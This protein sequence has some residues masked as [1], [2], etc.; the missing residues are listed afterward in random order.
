MHAK[1]MNHTLRH[2]FF[3]TL[4]SDLKS[5]LKS[6]VL[7]SDRAH[8]LESVILTLASVG[9]D[10]AGNVATSFPQSTTPTNRAKPDMIG[11][12]DE[13]RESETKACAAG[14]IST[15]PRRRRR[16]SLSLRIQILLLDLCAADSE[17]MLRKKGYGGKWGFNVVNGGERYP[18]N[19]S[20]G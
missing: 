5:E 17:S 4:I 10:E 11:Q 7:I 18:K 2:P 13:T 14:H 8:Q 12:G 16:G 1:A 3:L 19:A 20:R 6:Q 15:L 9:H